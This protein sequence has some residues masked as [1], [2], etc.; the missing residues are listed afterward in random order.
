MTVLVYDSFKD[1]I[2][3]KAL[4]RIGAVN[5]IQLSHDLMTFPVQ[6]ATDGRFIPYNLISASR[7]HGGRSL[8]AHL[9][10]FASIHEHYLALPP[11]TLEG[12]KEKLLFLEGGGVSRDY[13]NW[14]HFLLCD[15]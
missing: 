8:M 2:I 9:L 1:Q 10:P 14:C 4:T 11:P 13:C 12:E 6:T 3:V 7:R 15:K 5:I